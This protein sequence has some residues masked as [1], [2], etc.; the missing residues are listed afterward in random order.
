MRLVGLPGL[1]D[2]FANLVWAFIQEGLGKRRQAVLGLRVCHV[3]LVKGLG[4]AGTSPDIH[5]RPSL[6]L[7]QRVE[8]LLP[9][10]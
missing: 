8:F 10:H 9:L 6:G 5:A 2:H 4:N 3:Q 7:D 1:D